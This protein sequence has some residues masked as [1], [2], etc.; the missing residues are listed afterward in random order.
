M[1]R[2]SRREVDKLSTVYRSLAGFLA[3]SSLFTMLVV[4]VMSIIEGFHPFAIYGA[5]LSSVGLWV[6]GSVALTGYAPQLLLFTH[7]EKTDT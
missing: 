7:A 4:I 3:I 6:F 2:V 5:F 1:G